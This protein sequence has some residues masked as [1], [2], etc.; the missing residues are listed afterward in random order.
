M[1][2]L[3]YVAFAHKFDKM[4][5]KVIAYSQQFTDLPITVLTNIKNRCDGWEKCKNI[6]FVEIDDS[7]RNNRN[8]KTSMIDYSPYDKT[9]YMDVDSVIQKPGIEKVF[10][11]L[12]GHD[13]MLNVYGH[14]KDRIPLSYYRRVM[15]KL[16]VIA[17][18]TIYY[19]AFIGFRKTDKA[20][21]FF[22]TW[23]ANWKI[24]RTTGTQREMPALACTVKSMT[25]L[26]LVKT[27]NKDKVFT[28]IT[29]DGYI[30]QH[31]YGGGF[32]RKF[33]PEG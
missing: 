23:N 19:G 30:I 12:N 11:K 25:D 22:K 4:A 33:F 18:I 10:D 20:R 27:G 16:K 5:A 14:W 1:N 6:N 3:L 8:Y 26:K 7:D 24:S 21:E 17:P 15:A 32:W 2:G 28:W 31:E 13:I 29:R 9:I